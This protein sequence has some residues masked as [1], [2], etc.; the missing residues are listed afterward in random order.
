[1]GLVVSREVRGVVVDAV[2]PL[3]PAPLVKVSGSAARL[4]SSASFHHFTLLLNTDIDRMQR[5]LRRKQVCRVDTHTYTHTH[6]HTHTQYRETDTHTCMFAS[7]PPQ[8][9]LTQKAAT[10][11]VTTSVANLASSVDGLQFDSLCTA[12]ATVMWQEHQVP[13]QDQKVGM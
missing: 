1:M 12:I 10:P 2:L 3:H 7:L 5:Y 13:F 9:N 6:T 8:L 4:T 11:S